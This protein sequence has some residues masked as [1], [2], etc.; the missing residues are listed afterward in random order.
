MYAVELEEQCPHYNNH[1][2]PVT[3]RNRK[4]RKQNKRKEIRERE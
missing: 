3:G 4:M 2:D 1:E